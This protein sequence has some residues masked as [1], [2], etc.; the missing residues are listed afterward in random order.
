MT[1]LG[2]PIDFDTWYAVYAPAGT[3]RDI[4]E[5]LNANILRALSDP[6]L[7]ERALALGID[8]IGSSPEQ[9]V[10]HMRQEI[11]RWTA[12]SKAANIKAD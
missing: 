4:V 12:L 10:T 8:L 7:K 3:P 11:T 2:Y 6:G 5:K 1:E 9:L